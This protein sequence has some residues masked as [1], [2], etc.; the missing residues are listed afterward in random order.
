[1]ERTDTENQA[2][3]LLVWSWLCPKIVYKINERDV[4]NVEMSN[5]MAPKQK[6][7]DI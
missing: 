2:F 1:M 4:S 6:R 7:L 5:L 3:D